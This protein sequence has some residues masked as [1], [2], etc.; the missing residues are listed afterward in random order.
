MAAVLQL[1]LL[2]AVSNLCSAVHHKDAPF[3][4]KKFPPYFMWGTA[5]A[6]YQIEGAW[7][8]S[9]MLML[10]LNDKF[11]FYNSMY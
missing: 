6:S 3:L 5:T 4:H 10:I 2:F 8:I 9:G 11:T 7:N 1:L